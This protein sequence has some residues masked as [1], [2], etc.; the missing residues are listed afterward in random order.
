MKY[1][2]VQID[3]ESGYEPLN[4]ENGLSLNSEIFGA[5]HFQVSVIKI[6]TIYLKSIES[7]V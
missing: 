2:V 4:S 3:N 1:R 7:V 6:V 5:T